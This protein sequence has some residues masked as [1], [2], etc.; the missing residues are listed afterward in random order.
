MTIRSRLLAFI[1]ALLLPAFCASAFAVWYVYKEERLVQEKA[2]A[3]ASRSFSALVQQELRTYEATLAGLAQSPAIQAGNLEVGYDYAKR[4]TPPGSTIVLSEPGGR[5]IFNTRVPLGSAV[6]TSRSA[7]MQELVDAQGQNGTIVSDLFKART[8][9]SWDVAIQVPVM[10]NAKV[11]KLLGM[12]LSA[13]RLQ[14]LLDERKFPS[15]WLVT[16]VDRRGAVIARSAG[17]DKFVGTTIR[18]YSQRIIAAAHQGQYPSVTLDGVEVTAFFSRVP[19][20]DWTVL[21]SVSTDE[22][23]RVPRR[24]ALILGLSMALLLLLGVLAAIRMTRSAISSVAQL[25]VL[26]KAMH[27]GTAMPY[28]HCGIRELDGVGDAM[29]EGARTIAAAQDHLR[30]QVAQAIEQTE[31]VQH[32][33]LQGQKLEA[34]GR[35]SAGITHEFNNLLQT[36]LAVTELMHITNDVAK[37]RSLATKCRRAVERGVALTRQLK[38]FGRVQETQAEVVALAEQIPVAIDLLRELLP[39]GIALQV[40]VHPGS[41]LVRVD[42]LQL[43]LAILNVSIN[44][45]DAMP[46]GGIISMLV[47][48]ARDALPADVTPG[49]Y[50]IVSIRDNGQGMEADVLARAL[51]PFFTTKAVGTGTGLGLAQAYGFAKQSGGTLTVDSTVGEGTT[52]SMYLPVASPV[53]TDLAALPD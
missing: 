20:A 37:L 46:R 33:S 3:E 31:R 22:L 44:A 1:L 30:E 26:A 18:P 53:L 40:D 17:A 19:R 27:A 2:L 9:D 51:E 50:V 43:E 10:D 8:V 42:A 25:N 21:L 47:A 48:P 38:T 7:R 52:V 36:M 13:K 41:P 5:Q 15:T 4:V 6:P 49:Q 16:L 35:L 29:A 28:R 14:A 24:A 34:L 11:S 45:R 12:G 23:T 39:S 32:A